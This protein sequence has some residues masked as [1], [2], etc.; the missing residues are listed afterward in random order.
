MRAQDLVVG[1][2]YRHKN[3]PSQY[4]AKVTKILK[5]K[6]GVNPHSYTI[7]KCEWS[8]NKND[9]FGIVKHFRPADLIKDVSN[10]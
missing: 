4:W 5:P 1:R 6:Q 3:T 8:Q 9:S 7:V 2:S 10:D